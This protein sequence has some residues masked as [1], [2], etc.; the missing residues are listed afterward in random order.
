MTNLSGKARAENVRH[1]FTRIANRYDVTNRWMTWGQ[2]VRWRRDVLDLAAIPVGGRLLDIGA[3][4]GDLAIEAFRRDKSLFAVGADFTAEM[5]QL[6]RRRQGGEQVRWVNTDA[7]DLP[8]KV[9]YFDAVV[10]GYLLRNVVDVERALTEQYRVLKGGGRLVCL[11]TTPPPGDVW[12]LP[13]RLYL[14]FIIPILGGLL[15]GDISAYKYLP[16]STERFLKAEILAACMLKVGLR[17]VH[18]QR[19]M[20]GTMAIHWGVKKS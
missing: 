7:M 8:F 4:T 3:G 13:V 6:G 18:Y 12:H 2:D 1:M 9:G 5:M 19:F 15:A 11:D 20:G 10:S 16:R 14:R 17:D